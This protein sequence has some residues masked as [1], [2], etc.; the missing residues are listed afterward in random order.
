MPVKD[1]VQSQPD[2]E[3]QSKLNFEDVHRCDHLCEVTWIGIGRPPAS[4]CKRFSSKIVY[5]DDGCWLWKSA[6]GKPCSKRNRLNFAPNMPGIFP[7]AVDACR[8]IYEQ[9]IRKIDKGNQIDHLCENWRCVNPFHLDQCTNL[10]NN[11][12][13]RATRASWTL[14]DSLGRFAGRKEAP[15][16]VR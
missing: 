5:A 3:Y 16:G 14:R 11:K 12:R 10:E 15:N 2:A 6:I 7:H 8:W 9:V 13:Y 1:L 4:W